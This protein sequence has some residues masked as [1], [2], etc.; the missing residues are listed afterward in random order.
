MK[1]MGLLLLLAAC[2][3]AQQ[4]P[5]VDPRLV[6]T[7]VV[8]AN[9]LLSSPAVSRLA[10][11]RLH[12]VVTLQNPQPADFPLRVQTDWL[13]ATGAALSTA[14]SRPQFRLLPRGT[15]TTLDADAPNT[16]AQD[17]RM[18]LDAEGN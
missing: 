1:R 9:L 11:G 8:A 6:V 3:E 18:T 14:A 15:D 12:V 2:A 7:P 4:P 13:D 5:A 10:D 16:R 17:F